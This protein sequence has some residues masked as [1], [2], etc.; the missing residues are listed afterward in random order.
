ME[1]V[2]DHTTTTVTGKKVVI[3]QD[4][5][6]SSPRSLR[7]LDSKL[8]TFSGYSISDLCNKFK[9]IEQLEAYLQDN[10]NELVYLP[11]YMYMNNGSVDLNTC[12]DDSDKIGYIF[13]KLGKDDTRQE[14]EA[15]LLG[16]IDQMCLWLNDE[17]Y[18]VELYEDGE[19]IDC[20]SNFYCYNT[21]AMI[22][23]M[24]DGAPDDFAPLF[25]EIISKEEARIS[26]SVRGLVYDKI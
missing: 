22:M 12:G 18:N 8:Y 4:E 13:Q 16:E 14:V 21:V 5:F 20:A 26:N 24:K 17:V 7:Y 3:A 11:V 2:S 23:D 10:K 1:Y 9:D 15:Q 19:L 25:D 6:A